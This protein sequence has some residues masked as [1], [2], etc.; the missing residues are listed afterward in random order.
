MAVRE[1]ASFDA[2]KYRDILK[3]KLGSYAV[4]DQFFNWKKSL[5]LLQDDAAATDVF[6]HDI[7]KDLDN[8]RSNKVNPALS[9]L[10]VR[11]SALE[12][13][14]GTPFPG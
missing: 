6:A 4:F 5:D 7:K 14:G 12:G 8:W 11:V 10:D 1:L 2:A 3:Q 13:Q 9:D